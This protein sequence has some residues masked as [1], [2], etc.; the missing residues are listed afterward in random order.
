MVAVAVGAK[1]MLAR[2]TVVGLTGLTDRGCRV[3]GLK[4]RAA[5]RSICD[6]HENEHGDKQR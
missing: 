3:G 6:R 1:A 5:G 2:R 4:L